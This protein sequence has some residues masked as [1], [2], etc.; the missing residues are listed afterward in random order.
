[1]LNLGGAVRSGPGA[2][3]GGSAVD[4]CCRSSGC[5]VGME[6]AD[7][8]YCGRSTGHPGTCHRVWG[9]AKMSTEDQTGSRSSWSRFP[10]AISPP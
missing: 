4:G 2:R 3:S 10:L 6:F 8:G 5:D 1:V 9:P 7:D